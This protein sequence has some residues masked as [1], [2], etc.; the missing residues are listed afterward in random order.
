M[1]VSKFESSLRITLHSVN[2]EASTRPYNTNLTF[3]NVTTSCHTSS[4]RRT[5]TCVE[6]LTTTVKILIPY[7][8]I[9]FSKQVLYKNVHRWIKGQSEIYHIFIILTHLFCVLPY[10]KYTTY[11]SL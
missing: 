6:T 9:L 3:N 8:V 4:T 5:L 7:L 10:V 11:L 1:E 2:V